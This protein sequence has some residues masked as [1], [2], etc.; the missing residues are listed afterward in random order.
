MWAVLAFA[1]NSNITMLWRQLVFFPK[2]FCGSGNSFAAKQTDVDLSEY[3][4]R[5]PASLEVEKVRGRVHELGDSWC[6]PCLPTTFR[7]CSIMI[8]PEH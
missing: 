1:L 7:L 5:V 6:L 8:G 4:P 2:T 3:I